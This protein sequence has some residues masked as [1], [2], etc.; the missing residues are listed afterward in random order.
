MIQLENDR[1]MIYDRC[2]MTDVAMA[3]STDADTDA[4]VAYLNS[5][6]RSVIA[7][8]AIS[9]YDVIGAYIPFTYSAKVSWEI[10]LSPSAARLLTVAATADS[11]VHV[12]WYTILPPVIRALMLGAHVYTGGW[13]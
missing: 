7:L 6:S 3:I 10:I 9:C 12:I 1:F 5:W 13:V 11:L 8:I 2:P 4:D